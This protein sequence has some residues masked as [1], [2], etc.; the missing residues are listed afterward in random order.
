MNDGGI[1]VLNVSYKLLAFSLL[2]LLLFSNTSATYFYG[3]KLY[4]NG[5]EVALMGDFHRDNALDPQAEKQKLELLTIAKAKNA[6]CIMEDVFSKLSNNNPEFAQDTYYQRVFT[7]KNIGI[8]TIT[9]NS[10]LSYFYN[11]CLQANIAAANCEFRASHNFTQKIKDTQTILTLLQKSPLIRNEL[12][13][14]KLNYLVEAFE[15]NCLHHAHWANSMRID[16]IN[17]SL[18][19]LYTVHL[20]NESLYKGE[21]SLYI[22][23]V[24][25]AHIKEITELIVDLWPFQHTPQAHDKLI[26]SISAVC[27]FV[28]EPFPEL[29]NAVHAVREMALKHPLNISNFFTANSSHIL[30]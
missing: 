3:K 7:T 20:L 23:C 21:H 11:A 9:G 5:I 12:F 26:H 2:S 28:Y 6:Y 15:Q 1:I 16:Y 19:N 8:T 27:N 13:A 10:P 18:L 17:N 25:A 4:L 22:I 29:L 24:G 14:Q 30:N